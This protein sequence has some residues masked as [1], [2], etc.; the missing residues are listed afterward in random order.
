MTSVQAGSK[1][2]PAF[3]LAH[4]LARQIDCMK[5]FSD[6]VLFDDRGYITVGRKL[7]DAKKIGCP[8][9]VLVG[10]KSI[11]D[12]PLF[13]VFDINGDTKK[14]LTALETLNYFSQLRNEY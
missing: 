9:I 6:D 11:N 5:N 14:E 8:Y 3:P 2:E 13:E 7:V 12:L 1:E 4:Y 10:K